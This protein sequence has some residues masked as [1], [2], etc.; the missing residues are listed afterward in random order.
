MT[1]NA[2]VPL[3]S[4]SP[5]IFPPQNQGNMA[6]LQTLFSGDH[7]FNLTAAANDGYHNLIHM[8]LQAPT[9]VL[10][11]TGRLYVKTATSV[12]QLY[13]MDSAGIEYQIT[14]IAAAP[15]KITGSVAL[16]GS[17]TSGTVYT[18][19]DNS[20]GTIFV[21]YITPNAGDF[22]RYYLF[23]KSGT[24]FTERVL[25][26]AS[27]NTSRPDISISSSNIRIVNGNSSA[28]TV[29]YYIMVES[30]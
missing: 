22:Y 13:Y 25:L 17:A 1:F 23:Y 28:R 30:I 12:V 16:A 26:A 8:T 9:G 14:P 11:S 4:D 7:Q 18:I 24:T 27:S 10:A 15:T 2:S 29:G 20:Q 21:N 19:P 3:S 5:S 6:R